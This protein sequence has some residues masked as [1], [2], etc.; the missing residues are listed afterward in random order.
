M[1]FRSTPPSGKVFAGWD[2]TAAATNP[3]I[4]GTYTVTGNVTLYAIYVNE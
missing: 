3:D 4:T 2:T 1:L